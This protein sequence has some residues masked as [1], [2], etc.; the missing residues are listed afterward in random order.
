MNSDNGPTV[1]VGPTLCPGSGEWAGWGWQWRPCPVCQARIDVDEDT[2][3][4]VAHEK[5]E[6]WARARTVAEG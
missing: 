5:I 4:L 3:T 1:T 6:D 2:L